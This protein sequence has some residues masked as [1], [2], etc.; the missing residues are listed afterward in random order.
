MSK[1]NKITVF[2]LV[3]IYAITWV[4]GH[5]SHSKKVAS[6][7]LAMYEAVQEKNDEISA[8]ARR[9]GLADYE[10]VQLGEGGPKS[11]VKW[12]FPLLPG[13]LVVN[14]YYVIGPLWAEGG[15]KIIGYYGTSSRIICWISK[16]KS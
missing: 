14:S 10:P 9:E 15:I 3:A 2:S 13:I 11:D 12:S 7:A 4:G 1:K 5:L 6:N 8:F 16:W